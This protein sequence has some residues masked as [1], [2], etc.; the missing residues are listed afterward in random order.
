MR[1]HPGRDRVHAAGDDTTRSVQRA[2]LVLRALNG[3]EVWAL[4]ELQQ[5]TGLPKSTL[6][7]LLATLQAEGYVYSGAE[8]HGRY[9]L[10]QEVRQLSA[11]YSEKS[12]LAD[13]AAPIVIAATRKSRWP[14]AVGV[15]DGTEV[16]AVACTIPYSPYS[17][18]PTCYGQRFDLLGTAFGSTYLAFCAPRERR[19]LLQLLRQRVDPAAL[20]TPGA[21]RNF[22][23]CIR[24]RGYGLRAGTGADSPGIWRAAGRAG[25][26][27]LRAVPGPALD[28]PQPRRHARSRG[29]H[30][31]ELPVSTALSMAAFA[32]AASISPGPVNVVALASGARHGLRPSMRHVTGATVGFTALLLLAGLGLNTLTAAWPAFTQVLQWGG[33]AFLLYMAWALATDGGE[34][35]QAAGRKPP[36]M[37]L[38]A[39]MQWVNPK[40]W[41]ASAG[42]IGAFASSGNVADVWTFAAIYFVIC[43]GSIAA[44]AAAGAFLHQ[45]LGDPS[46]V[47]ALNR[48]LAATLVVSAG[49]MVLG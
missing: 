26:F 40:A 22:L 6:H 12:R 24:K 38:G 1:T 7:R 19:I 34:I 47:R 9:R 27:H 30:R 18:K 43:Y 15:I 46:K 13:V 45:V 42:G 28:R 31:G 23:G 36:S 32:L 35:G 29:T 5:A 16:R 41:L 37:L 4:G 21:L 20:P 11:G 49:Y 8:M 33:I 44:W 14:M 48:T 10:T 17:M 25:L 3:K 39:G 2:L